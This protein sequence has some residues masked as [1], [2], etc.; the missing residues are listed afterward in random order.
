MNTLFNKT[1][2]LLTKAK[3]HANHTAIKGKKSSGSEDIS[4]Y[5]NWKQGN[6]FQ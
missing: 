5:D 2:E 3:V 4:S 1:V 6:D